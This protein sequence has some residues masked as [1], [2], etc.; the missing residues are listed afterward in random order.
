MITYTEGVYRKQFDEEVVGEGTWELI[1]RKEYH[2]IILICTL[3]G[4]TF[5]PPMH[6][7]SV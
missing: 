1:I 4:K 5:Y 6:W 3:D 2:Y 7:E